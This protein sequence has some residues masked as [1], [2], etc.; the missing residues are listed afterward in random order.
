MKSWKQRIHLGFGLEATGFDVRR[1]TLEFLDSLPDWI[2]IKAQNISTT[3]LSALANHES[4][5]SLYP[6]HILSRLFP[7]DPLKNQ[8]PTPISVALLTSDKDLGVLPFSIAS[9]KYAATNPI[10]SLSVI[11]PSHSK[12]KVERILRKASYPTD[13]E[14]VVSTDEEILSN[15]G[16]GAIDFVSS[17]AKME[18]LKIVIGYQ[19]RSP[20]LI[21]DGD[22][23][24]LRPRNWISNSLQIT[25]VSQEYFL[26]HKNFSERL[27]NH[28][29]KTGWGYVTHHALFAPEQILHILEVVG[30]LGNLANEINS[31]IE[32][33]WTLQPEFPS[34][35]QLYGD[36]LFTSGSAIRAVPA[37]F[38]NIGMNRKILGSTGE[39]SQ[40][41]CITLLNRI[42]TA[43]PV[44]G[45][46]S[47]HD[48]K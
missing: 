7:F 34:E 22:T 1:L 38:S 46:I 23:L 11:C 20:I 26:G 42:K 16:L 8:Y 24:L 40:A 6:R 39:A 31:G 28:P 5:A 33:G 18:T 43:A 37:N 27:L 3:G 36:S 25:P 32:K 4:T 17:V 14:I 10:I 47:F 48:Y 21:L 19:S 30:G 9:L 41:D 2:K 13:F 29:I 44:L 15:A 45:S 35:W 12:Q